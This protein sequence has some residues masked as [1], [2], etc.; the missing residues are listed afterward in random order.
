MLRRFLLLHQ[1]FHTPP[2]PISSLSCYFISSEAPSFHDYRT[3]LSL[4]QSLV[5]R[6]AI[7]PGRQLHARLILSGLG[8]STVLATKLVNLYSVCSNLTYARHLFDRIP[9]QNLFLWNILIRGYAWNGP[10][11]AANLP[12]LT[13]CSKRGLV[14]ITYT[15]PFVLKA[16]SALS[17][18]LILEEVHQFLSSHTLGFGCIFVVAG[19]VD[20]Y[21]KC[22]CVDE[23]SQRVRW[24]A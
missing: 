4:L 5:A 7:E 17:L 10:Y 22:G 15:F 2:S 18:P 13:N 12:L 9:K 6:K 23:R 19:L 11:E 14:P 3:Y 16:C 21:S 24:N 20:M 8:L 1:H